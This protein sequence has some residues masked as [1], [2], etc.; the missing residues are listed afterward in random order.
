ML[1][2]GLNHIGYTQKNKQ[3]CLTTLL[4]QNDMFTKLFSAAYRLAIY[5]L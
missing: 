1:L 4:M 2:K 5:Y 3:G